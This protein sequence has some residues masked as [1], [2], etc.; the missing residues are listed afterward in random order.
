MVACYYYYHYY[1]L[2]QSSLSLDEYL[3]HI[4]LCVGGVVVVVDDGVYWGGGGGYILHLLHL[5]VHQ[6]RYQTWF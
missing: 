2:T 1:S 4:S 3:I 6:F 5:I